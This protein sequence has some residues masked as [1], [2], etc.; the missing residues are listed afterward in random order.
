MNA[1]AET[2]SKPTLSIV[3][4]LCNEEGNVALLLERLR[5]A[6]QTLGISYEVIL[7]D[8][9]SC[10]ATWSL[11]SE[12]AAKDDR[13]KGLSLSR[14]FGHQNALF[15]G[16][17]HSSGE[18]VVTMDGDMQHPPSLVPK[19]FEAWR[20]GNKVVETRRIES[21]DASLIKRMTSRWFYRI[22]SV[23]SGLPIAK[24]TSDFRL[25]DRQVV[26]TILQMKDAELFL[27]GITHWVGFQKTTITYKAERRHAGETKY[28]LLKMARFA[29]ASLFSFST[30]PL[31]LGIWLGL[32]TSGLAFLELIYILVNYFRGNVTPGWASTLTVISFM[33]GILFI[34]VGII[35]AYL[36][37]L[38][39]TLKNRPRFIVQD[40]SGFPDLP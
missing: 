24:G 17:Y 13:L 1:P 6:L 20:E 31:R 11:V 35:G 10:D 14:N 39:E 32:V 27:R 29:L 23:L 18:A 3:I 8:D 22:F 37:S 21:E 12:A 38:L 36:G 25:V 16:L 4:P 15:A 40:Q 5:D 9:G 28:G 2:T 26:D 30:I 7:V 34:V 19:L 33:F